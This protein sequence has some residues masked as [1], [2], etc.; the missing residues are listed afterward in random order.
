MLEAGERAPLGAGYEPARFGRVDQSG[1]TGHYSEHLSGV[2]L[3]IG[4]QM[5]QPASLQFGRDQTAKSS[6]RPGTGAIVISSMNLPARFSAANV[7][8]LGER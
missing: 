6:G 1:C 3:P 4:G 8:G 2:V 5:Y 7:S